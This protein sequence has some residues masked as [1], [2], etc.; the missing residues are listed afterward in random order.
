MD[1]SDGVVE[2]IDV[3]TRV[4]A[5]AVVQSVEQVARF[6][7]GISNIR[8][9]RERSDA[10]HLETR[11]SVIAKAESAELKAPARLNGPSGPQPMNAVL[12]EL[13]PTHESKTIDG[14]ARSANARRLAALDYPGVLSLE[15]GPQEHRGPSSRRPTSPRRERDDGLER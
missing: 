4:A 13:V 5:G 2:S 1:E 3:Q 9:Q 6:R 8:A 10:Q 14:E 11:A 7:S 15:D 12:S